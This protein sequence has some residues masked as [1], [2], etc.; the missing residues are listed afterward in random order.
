MSA[1]R[2]K[3]I[4]Q[5]QSLN[6]F[7]EGVNAAKLTAAHFHSWKMGLKTGMYYLRTKAAVDALSG[8][9]IDTSKYK[10]KPEQVQ[11]IQPK[12]VEQP[13][14]QASEELKALADQTM[15]DLSCSLDNPDD[16]LSCGS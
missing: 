14:K 3:F 2:G 13:A 6:L 10:E 15:D 12:V 4:C 8:L 9:G 5:S 1:D 11:L 16:C 7:I